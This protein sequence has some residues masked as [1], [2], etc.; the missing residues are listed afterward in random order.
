MVTFLTSLKEFLSSHPLILEVLDVI[1]SVFRLDGDLD[2]RCGRYGD[3][4]VGEFDHRLR[5]KYQG[6]GGEYLRVECQ[7]GDEGDLELGG[8]CVVL[9]AVI[10]AV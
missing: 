8:E 10:E 2:A 6:R 1:D 3:H 9:L 5:G 7:M 4:V